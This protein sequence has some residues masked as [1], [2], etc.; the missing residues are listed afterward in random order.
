MK[1]LLN[2]SRTLLLLA[3]S[4]GLSFTQLTPAQA[5]EGKP[6]TARID[7]MSDNT[8]L[9]RVSNPSQ[10]WSRVHLTQASSGAE[11]YR[12]GDAAPAFGRV[13]NL[14]NLEDGKYNLVVSTR[15][16]TSRFV[17]DVRT[18]AQQRVYSV[19]E[20]SVASR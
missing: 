17:L 18:Q 11:L 9:V 2:P 1:T 19:N 20:N 6:V 5:A 14:K 8:Y 12:S 15:E 16:G 3:A 10:K 7:K 4:L 13:L